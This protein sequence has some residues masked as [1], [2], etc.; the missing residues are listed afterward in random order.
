MASLI[1]P[2][3]EIQTLSI[4]LGV[5]DIERCLGVSP[6]SCT[7][8]ADGSAWC[9]SEKNDG[10]INDRATNWLNDR[11]L[12]GQVKGPVL[13]L[14]SPEQLSLGWLGP[15]IVRANAGTGD[16]LMAASQAFDMVPSPA[17]TNARGG[18]KA[19]TPNPPGTV[20]KGGKPMLPLSGNTFDVKDELKKLG[21]WWDAPARQWFIPVGKAQEARDIIAR[22]PSK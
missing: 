5:A 10:L 6:V 19:A 13:Y 22:G 1:P 2:S 14:S 9:H 7:V 12:V 16:P 11:G 18:R 15:L 4:P 3:G 20:T 21:A 17:L 8:A